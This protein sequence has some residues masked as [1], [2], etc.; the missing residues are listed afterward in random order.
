M[1]GGRLIATTAALCAAFAGFIATASHAQETGAVTLFQNVRIFDGTSRAL[2]AP[3]RA[4][5]K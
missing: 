2:S 1:S 4:L 5:V 3:S